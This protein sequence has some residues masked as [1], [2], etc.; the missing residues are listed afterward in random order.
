MPT[1]IDSTSDKV[2][3]LADIFEYFSGIDVSD[4]DAILEGAPVLRALAN[5]RTFLVERIVHE[6]KDVA[7]LQQTNQYSSQVFS[8]GR[9]RNFFMRA[10]FWPA[11]RDTVLQTSGPRSFFYGVPHDHNFDFLTVGYMGPGYW[12]DFYEYDHD[13]VA[14]YPGEIVP[15]RFTGR[16]ALP[17]GRMMLYHASVD[18]HSQMPADSF[19]ISLNVIVDFP[20]KISTINQYF[21][22]LESYRIESFANRTSLPLICEVAGEIGNEDCVDVL[23]YLS[24]NHPHTRG[25]IAA[26]D[27]L[28][29]LCPANTSTIWERAANDRDW[30]MKLQARRRL[31]QFALQG[32]TTAAAPKH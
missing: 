7:A 15:L 20:E 22:D 2:A 11:A 13:Q 28:V 26:Y 18:V 25:R 29:R 9:G 21:F 24:A 4:R 8:L 6:L 10:N 12:S 5:N 19:S 31:E 30:R 27:A 14:G 17:M 23:E 16:E 3:T 32:S 1:I